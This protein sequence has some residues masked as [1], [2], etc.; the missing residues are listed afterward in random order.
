MQPIG[1]MNETKSFNAHKSINTVSKTSLF[2][3]GSAGSQ[4]V[5]H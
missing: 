4:S 1:H 2:K 5:T 3:L